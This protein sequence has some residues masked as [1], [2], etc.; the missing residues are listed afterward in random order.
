MALRARKILRYVVSLLKICVVLA[1]CYGLIVL[2]TVVWLFEVKLQRWPL[3]IYGAPFSVQVGDDLK[4]LGLIERLRRQGYTRSSAAMPGPGEWTQSAAGLTIFLKPC[5]MKGQD[6]VTGPVAFELDSGRIESIRLLRSSEKANRVF[7]EP[8]LIHV[9]AARGENPQLCR[10]VGLTAVPPLLLDAVVLTE[11]TRFFS[12][13]GVDPTSMVRALE[14]N[15]K[16]RRYV[17]GG[18]TIPQQL[19]R[20]T[21]L[22]P[23]KILLRK[24]IEISLAITA[25]AVYSKET[26]LQ[27]YLNR[28]Y[29]GHWGPFPIKGVAEACRHLFAKELDELDASECALLAATIRAPNILNPLRHPDR[30]LQRRNVILGILLRAGKISE[31]V[32]EEALQRP[33]TMRRPGA[34]PVKAA[35]FIEFIKG[36]LPGEFSGVGRAGSLKQDAFTSLDPL[37]QHSVD[38]QLRRLGERGLQ[39]HVIVTNPETGEIKALISPL[40]RTWSGTG[41]N[42]ESVLPMIIIPALIPERQES[43][44]CTLTSPVMPSDQLGRTVTFRQAFQDERGLLIQRLATSPGLEKMLWVLREFGIKASAG[45]LDGLAVERLTPLDMAKS[46]SL[47]AGLGKAPPLD[48]GVRVPDIPRG[49]AA[50]ETRSVQVKPAVLFLVNHLLKKVQGVGEVHALRGRT[51]TRPSVFVACDKDGLWGVAYRR[52]ALVV[53]RV[54]G[55]AADAAPFE[56]MIPRLLPPQAGRDRQSQALPD[57]IVFREI[58]VRSGLRATSIC[59]H[60]IRESFLKGTQPSEWCPLRH[61]PQSVKPAPK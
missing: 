48:A 43:P 10:P 6:I 20:M 19:I 25:D 5:P 18:S 9:I 31:Q 41:G 17:Q 4:T 12:H 24:A 61:E 15:V 8:E 1:G 14:T 3:F 28:V 45:G 55:T 7:L 13:S 40:P 33:V 23:E 16:A 39:A 57:G 35:A 58:C 30:A 49:E 34:P 44:L 37:L 27:S 32:Y 21:L 52:D 51:R 46:Y 38:L 36:R 56:K 29:L 22:S 26:I 59:P 42:L 11:D 47:L 2:G 54:P 53:V 60:V 50:A